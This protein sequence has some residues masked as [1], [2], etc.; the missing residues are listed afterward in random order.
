MKYFVKLIHISTRRG[1]C[2]K[3]TYIS[4]HS[5]VNP[6]VE[7]K[8]VHYKI[9]S[10]YLRQSTLMETTSPNSGVATLNGNAPKMDWKLRVNIQEFL[11]IK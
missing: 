10:E 6:E 3:T 2:K 7:R 5:S 8:V 1:S 4:S 9:S 11:K